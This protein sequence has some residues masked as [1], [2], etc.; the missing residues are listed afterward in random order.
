VTMNNPI[1]ETAI[2]DTLY[3]LTVTRNVDTAGTVIRKPDQEWV[4]KGIEDT[5][6]AVPAEDGSYIFGYWSGDIGSN[7]IN[8]STIYIEMDEAKNIQA[9]FTGVYHTLITEIEPQNKRGTILVTPENNEYLH[10]RKITVEAVPNS[11]YV[12]SYWE[13]AVTG[14]SRIAEFNILSDDTVTAH[15]G[16]YDSNP[17]QVTDCYPPQNATQ[18]AVNTD[19][20]FKVVDDDYS[21]T[22]SSLDIS[23]NGIQ[24]VNNGHHRF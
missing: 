24:I 19:I 14:T 2:W 15:F 11:G 7:D 4:E 21:V 17:P 16:V 20:E 9:N 6:T 12:F 18:V 10:S 23:V 5:L 1:T 3:Q 13:G 8:S 22:L